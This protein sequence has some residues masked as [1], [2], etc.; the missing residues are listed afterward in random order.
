MRKS[1]P[2]RLRRD[3]WDRMILPERALRKAEKQLI[4]WHDNDKDRVPNAQRLLDALDLVRQAKVI[5]GDYEDG[6]KF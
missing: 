6:V 4:S 2:Q 3:T 5:V 1:T